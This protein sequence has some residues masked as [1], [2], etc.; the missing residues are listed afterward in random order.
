MQEPFKQNLTKYCIKQKCI[1]KLKLK[2]VF[3]LLLLILN[4]D[5]STASASAVGVR[6]MTS[7]SSG[8][9]P[10]WS[11]TRPVSSAPSVKCFLMKT[12]PVLSET[13]KPSARRI[14][15]GKDNQTRLQRPFYDVT[16]FS[17]LACQFLWL[18][19]RTQNL[20]RQFCILPQ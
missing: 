4:Q 11:G 18:Q 1:V 14:T 13:E 2:L 7:T 20:D 19:Y 3:C 9:P 16:N 8:W 15:S 17:G 5:D 10:T 6:S 12:V